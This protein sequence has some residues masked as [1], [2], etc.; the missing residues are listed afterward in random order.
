MGLWQRLS[1]INVQAGRACLVSDLLVEYFLPPAHGTLDDV[2]SL[3]GQLLLHLTLGAPQHEWPQ[4][5][6]PGSRGGMNGGG[7]GGG[8]QR[9]VS[10]EGGHRLGAAVT[11]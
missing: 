1:M 5:L 4:H 3:A 2:L 8:V 7:G 6:H 11:H 9:W 10:R